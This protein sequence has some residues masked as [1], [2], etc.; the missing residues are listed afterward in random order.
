MKKMKKV[1][2]MGITALT[3]CTA[4]KPPLWFIEEEENKD[5]YKDRQQLV[6]THLWQRGSAN[7]KDI[8]NLITNFNNSDIAK[9]LNIFVKGDGTN[10]WDYWTK[11]NLSISG[12]S[13]PDIFI[14]EVSSM[15]TRQKQLLN[16]SEMYR[17][18]IANERDTLDAH[19]MF[20]ESQIND[21]DKY[22]ENK[23]DLHAWP[24]SA[25][26][27]VVYY[28]K[29][30]FA[31]AGITEV[32]KT[33]AEMEEV[34]RKLTIYEEEGNVASGYKQVGFDPFTAEGQ[35]VHQWGWLSGQ[36]YWT[37]DA[38]TGK[39]IPHFNDKKH[40]DNINKLY[41]SYP[42]RDEQAR[43]NLQAFMAKYAANGQNP[44]VNGQL[45][46]VIN[47]EGL[48]TTL[49][50]AKVEFE[51]GIFEIPPM[52]ETCEYTNWSSSY[53]L[54]LYDNAKRK[55]LTP[56]QVEQRNRG[57]WEFMKYLYQEDAQKVIS[58]AGFMLSNKLFHDK[59]INNDP[60]KK[61]LALAIQ[62]TKEAEFIAAVPKWTSEIQTY[63]NN[64]YSR[65]MDVQEAMDTIQNHLENEVEKYYIQQV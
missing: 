16:L 63:V 35:Y 59:F 34:N 21:I 30:L 54:E 12:G 38:N 29:D 20:F 26:V 50:E 5:Q 42:R 9:E 46:M 11:V 2:L 44:F 53:S 6:F 47:N 56:E 23:E 3:L 61:E 17:Q 55:N 62:H 39:P 40:V 4:C 28:N 58:D 48:Y 13:A 41:T 31:Q 15:P 51:Y 7:Y 1:L 22:S 60:I 33:W 52:D 14:H 57:A 32:P 49:Q 19:E 65:V 36:E 10:F 18:D 45:A 27:R 43:D 64:I 37:Y 24:F 25:T 8:N